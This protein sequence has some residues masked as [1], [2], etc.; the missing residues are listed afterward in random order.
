M[1]KVVAAW[2]RSLCLVLPSRRVSDAE[3]GKNG[4]ESDEENSGE[5]SDSGGKDS[6]E[7][8]NESGAES[9][10]ESGG[11]SGGE[12][13]D[14]SSGES[15]GESGVDSNF[16]DIEETSDLRKGRSI[17]GTF[18]GRAGDKIGVWTSYKR[19]DPAESSSADFLSRRDFVQA[20]GCRDRGLA[21]CR[22]RRQL[23]H[24]FTGLVAGGL[25][26][27]TDARSHHAWP[28]FQEDAALE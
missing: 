5:S 14:V 27:P 7:S 26:L 17:E 1:T 21:G 3:S 9:G 10:A 18:Y 6:N 11:E 24:G 19:F 22:E 13:D 4:T 16:D 8:G 28:I 23:E 12:S 15:G 20:P 2:G 25:Q